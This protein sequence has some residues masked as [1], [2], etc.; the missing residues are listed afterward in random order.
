MTT[1]RP[2]ARA[3]VNAPRA[4]EPSNIVRY[5]A[6]LGG[7]AEPSDASVDS[8][9]SPWADSGRDSPCSGSTG[10]GGG[11]RN[12]SVAFSLNS[13][14]FVQPWTHDRWVEAIE[15]SENVTDRF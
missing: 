2:A 15:L 8:A 9:F 5:H 12:R 14:A 10:I 13:I 6:L 1:A 11:C 7:F 3:V 4:V